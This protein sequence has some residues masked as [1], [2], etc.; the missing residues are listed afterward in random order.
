MAVLDDSCLHAEVASSNLGIR[1]THTSTVMMT[2]PCSCF[3]LATF[4]LV[5][6]ANELP[7]SSMLIWSHNSWT[8]QGLHS[9]SSIRTHHL[10]VWSCRPALMVS[11]SDIPGSSSLHAEVASYELEVSDQTEASSNSSQRHTCSGKV[12]SFAVNNM[13]PGSRYQVML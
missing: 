3:H 5:L 13:Q 12:Q 2:N 6:R 1:S 8:C 10:S 9:R 11:W 4:C 7:D